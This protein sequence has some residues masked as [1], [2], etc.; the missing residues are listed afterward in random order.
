MATPMSISLIFKQQSNY[1]QRL[2]YLRSKSFKD[3]GVGVDQQSRY[4][5]GDTIR[6]AGFAIMQP[7]QPPIARQHGHQWQ[8]AQAQDGQGQHTAEQGGI[9]QEWHGQVKTQPQGG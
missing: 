8:I 4:R 6:H 2:K 1:T 5:Q 7:L 9:D 3:D